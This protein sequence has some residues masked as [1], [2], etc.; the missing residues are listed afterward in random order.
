MRIL[1][2]RWQDLGVG[3]RVRAYLITP[4]LGLL[5]ILR[6]PRHM[7]IAHGAWEILP[8]EMSWRNSHWV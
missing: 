5:S 2:L 3:L 8:L 4:C 7:Q 1:G 6:D